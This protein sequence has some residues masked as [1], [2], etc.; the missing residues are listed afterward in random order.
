MDFLIGNKVR[1]V[2][3]TR[4]NVTEEYLGWLNDPEVNRYLC[5]GRFPV[6]VDDINIYTGEKNFLFAIMAKPHKNGLLLD[7]EPE[8]TNYIGTIS[9]HNIDWISRKGEVGYMIGN[10]SYW[11][12]GIATE[13]VGLIT[14]YGFMR[15]NLNKMYAGI[16]DGN[17]GSVKTLLRNRYVE[18]ANVP[19]EYFLNGKFLDVTMFYKLQQW[20]LLEKKC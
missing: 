13:I 11:G 18:Y 12:M 7:K 9:L 19:Q 14:E 1:L 20:H 5:T 10:K 3:F 4:E 8:Y 6:T 17:I 15:I 2:K 16:V